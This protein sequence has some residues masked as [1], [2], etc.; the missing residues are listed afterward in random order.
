MRPVLRIAG[1]LLVLAA[2]TLM[3]GAPGSAL[4]DH[5]FDGPVTHHRKPVDYAKMMA[6][7]KPQLVLL[8][9][10][11][12]DRAVADRDFEKLIGRPCVVMKHRGGATALWYIMLKNVIAAAEPPPEAVAIFFRTVYL[13]EPSYRVRA[14][15][16]H[17][18]DY[19]ID[20]EEPEL[21]RIAY[22]E[23]MNRVAF[24]L[25][26]FWSL[27]QR[28]DSLR[29]GIEEVFK[30]DLVGKLSR[31]TS[32]EVRSSVDAAFADDN[33]RDE[34]VEA[35]QLEAELDLQSLQQFDFEGQVTRSF[36]PLILD[37]ARDSGI[38]LIFVRM[39]TQLD[40][41][42][43]G[44]ATK[45]IQA[46]GEFIRSHLPQYI[47]SLREYLEANGAQLLDLSGDDLLQPSH[48]QHGDHLNR[49]GRT[50][51]TPYLAEKLAPLLP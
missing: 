43:D 18:I 22:F 39:R 25:N 38:S 47:R 41:R 13:T 16:K 35:A 20:G 33:M 15:F 31:R 2:I 28:R 11:V 21:D 36:L 37:V 5:S 19:Y 12:L 3:V 46:R 4:I 50:L 14:Q 8:G 10:S 30:A 45:S 44:P 23:Q 40:A 32:Q 48:F 26:R 34:W 9:N 29:F 24:T 1:A 7:E 27:Y 49:A 51:F 42:L 6:D 17:R